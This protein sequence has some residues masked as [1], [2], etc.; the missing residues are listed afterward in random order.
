M[1]CYKLAAVDRVALDRWSI[2]PGGYEWDIVNGCVWIGYCEWGT[3]DGVIIAYKP[4]WAF[5]MPGNGVQTPL[6]A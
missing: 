5:R 2:M 3:V 4:Y 6:S 1:E